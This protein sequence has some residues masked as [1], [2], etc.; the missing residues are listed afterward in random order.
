V[1]STLDPQIAPSLLITPIMDDPGLPSTYRGQDFLWRQRPQ[2]E[3]IQ[4]A[5]WL[6]W[7]VF[8]QLPMEN[9]TVILWARDDLFP[10]ARQGVEP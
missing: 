7:I 2:W 4:G 1:V 8:R 6:K 10:D 9:E 3:I 5:D